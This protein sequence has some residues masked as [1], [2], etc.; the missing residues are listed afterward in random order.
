MRVMRQRLLLVAGWIVAAV[1]AG[2]VASGAVAVAG[3]QVFDRHV[4]PLNAAEVAALPVDESMATLGSSAR[5]ASGGSQA[6]TG[7][8]NEGS[9][10]DTAGASGS[11][12]PAGPGG[13]T[14]EPGVPAIDLSPTPPTVMH[15][16]G[17][18]AS[19]GSDEGGL[20]ILWATPKPNYAVSFDY[21]VENQLVLVFTSE[22]HRSVI[23][24][25][26]APNGEIEVDTDEQSI[27]EQ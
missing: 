9:G 15:V 21:D 3:G 2:V 10:R 14:A 1:G 16:S 18:S 6:S 19:I 20:Q 26:Q 11:E 12:R 8:A 23:S 4:R 22:G 13:V 7:D 27:S 24:I 25:R 5:L 17:G